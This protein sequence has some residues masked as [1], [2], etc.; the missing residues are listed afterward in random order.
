MY[1]NPHDSGGM[2]TLC[3]ALAV[4]GPTMEALAQSYSS[5]GLDHWVSLLRKEKEH[6]GST[7]IQVI[8]FLMLMKKND[9]GT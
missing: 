7:L 5:H 2:L 1:I 3:G 8:L 6:T 4:G 9:T